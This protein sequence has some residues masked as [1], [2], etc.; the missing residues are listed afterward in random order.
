MGNAVLNP[1]SVL[2]G[3]TLA[4][5]CCSAWRCSVAAAL[6]EDVLAVAL[7]LGRT[8]PVSFG[9]CVAGAERVEGRG[10]SMLQVLQAG[11]ELELD[12]LTGPVIERARN[13]REDV[14]RL[15][16]LHAATDLTVRRY[17]PR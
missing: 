8:T 6:V 7:A 16:T 14:P 15:Q 11:K 10:T 12:P 3:A 2:T 1:L 17:G 9:G 13:A 4:E 5:V